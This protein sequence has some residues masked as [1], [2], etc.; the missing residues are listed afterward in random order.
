VVKRPHRCEVSTDGPLRRNH[1]VR[2]VRS[3]CPMDD[4][5]Q[6][7]GRTMTMIELTDEQRQELHKEEPVRLIDPPRVGLC[8]RT[9]GS[10]P[11]I[12]RDFSA[13]NMKPCTRCWPSSTQMIG[14]SI[15]VR[16]MK[17]RGDVFLLDFPCSTVPARKC[18]R[19]HRASNARNAILTHYNCRDGDQESEPH[20]RRPDSSGDRHFDPMAWVRGFM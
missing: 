4:A 10:L 6:N 16:P 13:R 12:A 2:A 8:A 1:V 3:P 20:R 14:K 15:R 18:A 17:S 9:R 11:S 19:R 5:A 7:D